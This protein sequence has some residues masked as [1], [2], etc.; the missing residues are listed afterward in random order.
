MDYLHQSAAEIYRRRRRHRT[1][2]TMTLITLLLVSTVAY[3]ASNVQGWI[4]AVGP[5]AA[6]KPTC[7]A[8]AS[9]NKP[10]E[11]GDVTIN[12]Y[13]T[14][15]RAGLASS[16]ASSLETQGFQVATI[17]NDPLGRSIPS[18]G[19]IRHGLRGKAGAMLAAA[20]LPGAALVQD[21]RMDASVDLV[22][23][24]TFKAIQEPSAQAAL[25]AARAARGC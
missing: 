6:G 23:G 18:L 1:I 17:D 2:M 25:R 8:V 5:N 15:S 16:V 12:V 24:K 22:L 3:A 19:E 21:D 9:K 10:L 13:N 4:G 14:T 11:P 7:S 20:R